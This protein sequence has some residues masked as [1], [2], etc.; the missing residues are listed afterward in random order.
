M[1]GRLSRFVHRLDLAVGDRALGTLLFDGVVWVGKWLW[2]N[3][4]TVGVALGSLMLVA[5]VWGLSP[6]A[7]GFLVVFVLLFH[8]WIK[9]RKGAEH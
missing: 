2:S 1:W 4:W 7:L 8:H 9:T 6:L 5:I 3:P